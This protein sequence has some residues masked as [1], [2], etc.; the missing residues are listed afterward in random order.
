MER[1]NECKTTEEAYDL[2]YSRAK[3]ILLYGTCA[4]AL[5]YG[6]ASDEIRDAYEHGY[7]AV[8]NWSR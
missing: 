2:G 1:L 6:N 3:E 7:Q 5:S 8:M 4:S